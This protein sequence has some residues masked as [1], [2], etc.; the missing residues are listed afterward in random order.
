MLALHVVV[1]AAYASRIQFRDLAPDG[2][3]F[4]VRVAGIALVVYLLRI[5]V[6][7]SGH[8]TL[9]DLAIRLFVMS[10]LHSAVIGLLMVRLT[11]GAALR[12]AEPSELS[13]SL[14]PSST[15]D[16]LADVQPRRG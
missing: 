12:L 8:L 2:R 10:L 3:S 13:Q 7:F 11:R 16:R 4:I 15:S 1:F 5:T 14:Y 9:T 6:D